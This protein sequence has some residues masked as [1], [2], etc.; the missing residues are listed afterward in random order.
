MVRDFLQ[1]FQYFICLIPSRNLPRECVLL[2]VLCVCWQH[3]AALC[4]CD[5]LFALLFGILGEPTERAKASSF[6][7]WL[8][9]NLYTVSRYTGSTYLL[10]G[11]AVAVMM[12]QEKGSLR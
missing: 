3:S 7:F 6:S 11:A 5:M 1:T 10:A 9:K 2:C 4:G 8:G 12:T